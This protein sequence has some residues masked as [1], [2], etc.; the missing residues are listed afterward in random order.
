MFRP[1]VCTALYTNTVSYEVILIRYV[2][3]MYR[4]IEVINQGRGVVPAFRGSSGF[5]RTFQLS[6]HSKLSGRSSCPVI[7]AIFSRYSI[8]CRQKL[9]QE[10]RIEQ[11]TACY[12]LSKKSPTWD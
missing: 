5:P 11:F 12:L 9:K 8:P 4:N 6:G 10:K 3:W 1:A 2:L 7:L